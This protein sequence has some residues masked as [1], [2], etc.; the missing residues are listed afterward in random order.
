MIKNIY[1]RLVLQSLHPRKN[2]RTRF[3]PKKKNRKIIYK[4][5]YYKKYKEMLNY[6]KIRIQINHLK[7]NHLKKIHK[8]NQPLNN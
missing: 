1:K 7:N 2:L 4:T 6:F 3:L 8:L 5:L